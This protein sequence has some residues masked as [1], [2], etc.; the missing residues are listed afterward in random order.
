MEG[1]IISSDL[2]GN[3]KTCNK[4]KEKPLSDELASFTPIVI[5]ATDN[6]RNIKCKRL[7]TDAVYR[8]L[9]KTMATNV[10]RDFTEAIVV[11][12]VNKNIIFSKPTVQGLDSYFIVNAKEISG[13]TNFTIG[14]KT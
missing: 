11:E 5:S 10:D 1:L 7:D 12:L 4:N 9:S 2:E 6:I 13:V 8:Y 3:D 14:K